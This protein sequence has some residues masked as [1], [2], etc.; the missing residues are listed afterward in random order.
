MSNNPWSRSDRRRELL[1]AWERRCRAK[2]E[3]DHCTGADALFL[4]TTLTNAIRRGAATPELGRAARTWG[5]GFAS[6]VEALAT[7]THLRDALTDV[8]DRPTGGLAVPVAIIN[9][10]FDQVMMEAV[11]AAST[12]LRSVARKDPLTGCANRR[13]LDEELGHAVASARRSG[14][15]LTVAIADLD[16]L[17]RIN[18]NYGHAAGDT[19]LVS[20]VAVLRSVL[21]EADTLYRTGG[22]EFVVVA[23]FTEPAG[24]R[25]LMSRAERIGGPSFSWGIASLAQLPADVAAEMVAPAL[26]ATADGDLYQRR[27]AYRQAILRAER[28]RRIV[29]VASLAASAAALSGGAVAAALT[30]GAAPAGSPDAGAPVAAKAPSGGGSP[31]FSRLHSGE[32][33]QTSQPSSALLGQGPPIVS[34]VGASKP[35][36]PGVSSVMPTLVSSLSPPLTSVV[37][38][39]SSAVPA[40][41]GQAVNLVASV[42]PEALGGTVSFLDGGSVIPSCA[43]VPVS[44][45]QAVCS[46]LYDVTGVHTISALFIPASSG[47]D[48]SVS[49][50]LT[51][52][53][54][55]PPWW[56]NGG[57]SGG[58]S[59]HTVGP[60]NG[61]GDGD[62]QGHHW[63]NGGGDQ[64][65][66]GGP[67]D[68]GQGA[69]GG[70]DDSSGHSAGGW[71]GD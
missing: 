52:T 54:T 3:A 41:V 48:P 66:G 9:R 14:L 11:D 67:G 13:A 68:G 8:D 60:G 33:S 20:L 59:P 19:A 28:K 7:L 30:I 34:T 51:E 45:G 21:R 56:G 35:E 5:A 71:N 32:G 26:L 50:A 12:N 4:V 53:V 18:D 44:N 27:R 65:Q 37:D 47:T 22:D 17:K 64:Q 70:H 43:D 46:V 63:G 57:G 31:S 23:P 6:P 69:W 55:A 2:G 16:G 61:N 36:L 62:G 15:D 58:G 1:A 39:T 25:A 24:A 49:S 42:V 38:L 29:T 10:V 40:V